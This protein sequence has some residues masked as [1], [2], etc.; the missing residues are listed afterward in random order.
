MKNKNTFF[1]SASACIL[2][3]ILLVGCATAPLPPPPP[4]SAAAKITYLGDLRYISVNDLRMVPVNN[5]FVVNADIV[6]NDNDYTAIEYRFQWRDKNGMSVG[7]EENWT[8]LQFSPMQTQ[9]I[10]GTATSPYVVDFKLELKS[11]N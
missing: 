8:T 10:K 7:K 6:N 9:R 3:S 4:N 2:L 11:K 1:K 5:F